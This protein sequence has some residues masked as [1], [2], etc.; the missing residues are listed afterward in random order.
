MAKQPMKKPVAKKTVA[1]VTAKKTAVKPKASA[2][3]KPK[4][5]PNLK[6]GGFAPGSKQ[7]EIMQ[8]QRKAY[9]AGHQG[10]PVAG[11]KDLVRKGPQTKAVKELDALRKSVGWKKSGYGT[12]SETKMYGDNKADKAALKRKADRRNKKK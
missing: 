1:K 7:V 11:L 5:S 10:S 9:S 3:A 6:K 12:G 4:S 8:A 2:T